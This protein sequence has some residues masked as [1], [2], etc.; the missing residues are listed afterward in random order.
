MNKFILATVIGTLTLGAVSC[1][2]TE[3]K[4]LKKETSKEQVKATYKN[5]NSK[6]FAE[7]MK[8]EGAQLVDVR[9]PEEYRMYNIE[10]FELVNVHDKDFVKIIQKF[11]KNKPVLVHCKAGV[12]GEKAAQIFIDNGFTNV[13]NL[14]GGLMA[15]EAD[16]MEVVKTKKSSEGM[17]IEAYDKINQE[18]KVVLVDFNAPWCGPCRMMKPIIEELQKEYEG[19]VKVIEVNVDEAEAL[20]QKLGI[21]SIPYFVINKDGQQVWQ[22][23]GAMDKQELKNAIEESLK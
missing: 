18:N 17:S 3:T 12:R 16:G 21:R 22:K 19:K 14:D 9:T 15:W 13:M 1:Q 7:S 2:T 4:G 10:G 5:V 11:D 23:L 6:E 20:S 8:L